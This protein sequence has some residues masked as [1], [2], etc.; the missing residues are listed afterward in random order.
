MNKTLNNQL[1]KNIINLKPYMEM[2]DY[3]N[4]SEEKGL[5]LDKQ[6]S[7]MPIYYNHL[8]LVAEENIMKG[9]K[10]GKV[11]IETG[12][13]GKNINLKEKSTYNSIAEEINRIAKTEIDHIMNPDYYDKYIQ[14]IYLTMNIYLGYLDNKSEMNNFILSFPKESTSLINFNSHEDGIYKK[15]RSKNIKSH[16]LVNQSQIYSFYKKMI[17]N[18]L[19]QLNENVFLYSYLTT[20]TLKNN[21]YTEN[22]GNI[23]VVLPLIN[24]MI[25]SNLANNT[26]LV[27]FYDSNE[28]QSSIY[29]L[30]N[31]NI[32]KGEYLYI[33]KDKIMSNL[34]MSIKFGYIEK[35]NPCSDLNLYIS[36]YSD[37]INDYFNNVN[38]E[39]EGMIY[40]LNEN[41]DRKSMICKQYESILYAGFGFYENKLSQN[42]LKLLRIGFLSSSQLSTENVKS[43]N[44]NQKFS[45]ENEIIVIKYMKHIIDYYIN[46]L[47]SVDEY[48]N[49]ISNLENLIY[50]DKE[51]LLLF[52]VSHIEMEEKKILDKNYSYFNK[53]I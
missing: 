51:S 24:Q 52:N 48:K 14:H 35:S 47:F 29:L 45:D 34:E 26:D 43:H 25:H 20:N 31:R 10:I 2:Y 13:T 9:E 17:E 7:F 44:F 16:I 28:K 12:M 15:I 21:I 42:L 4:Y 33:N 27:N 22:K 5:S 40:I 37:Y 39:M 6:I 19:F 1:F 23:S 46:D 38:K 32:T 30:A 8:G 36:C 53:R 18:K 49:S 11:P 3:L 41:I 50:S